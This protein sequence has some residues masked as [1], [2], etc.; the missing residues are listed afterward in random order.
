[1]SLGNKHLKRKFYCLVLSGL[2][3]ALSG[4]FGGDSNNDED[5]TPGNAPLTLV[6]D[7]NNAAAALLQS[8]LAL[9][10]LPRIQ[11]NANQMVALGL[12]GMDEC[13][14]QDGTYSIEFEDEPDAGGDPVVRR[15]DFENCVDPQFPSRTFNGSINF[16]LSDPNALLTYFDRY[17]NITRYDDD[18]SLQWGLIGEFTLQPNVADEPFNNSLI[19]TRRA[20]ASETIVSGT[21]SVGLRF[22]FEDH[23][24]YFNPLVSSET[25]YPSLSGDSRLVLRGPA[26]GRVQITTPHYLDGRNFDSPFCY[27]TGELLVE[28]AES[29]RAQMDY[30]GTDV[31]VTVNGVTTLSGNCEALIG[32]LLEDAGLA[33]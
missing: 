11:R 3:M 19:K 18:N 8:R 24:V 31:M 28:G 4:C 32:Q 6:I 17:T 22:E 30:N 7:D 12:N 16:D 25:P 23:T 2:I 20:I 15:A 33:L 1:M 27:S 9:E 26:D 21:E 29:T 10:I 14:N 5:Q 13:E